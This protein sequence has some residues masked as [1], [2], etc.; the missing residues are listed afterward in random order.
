MAGLQQRLCI[1]CG[2]TDDHPRH[3]IGKQAMWHMD[4]HVLATDCATCKRQ[5]AACDT[6]TEP[7]GVIGDELRSRLLALRPSKEG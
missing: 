6:S 7:D 5:L 2:Q 1:G 4:C 3:V